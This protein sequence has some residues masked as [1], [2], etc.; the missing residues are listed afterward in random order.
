MATAETW[1]R[2]RPR[3]SIMQIQGADGTL[4]SW[5]PAHAL[6][7]PQWDKKWKRKAE[8]LGSG[9]MCPHNPNVYYAWTT[10]ACMIHDS[11]LYINIHTVHS[12]S[13]EHSSIQSHTSL[14]IVCNM[15]SKCYYTIVWTH[16]RTQTVTKHMQYT[17]CH[18]PA[19]A[20]NRMLINHK[21]KL[22]TCGG[23]VHTSAH[24][25]GIKRKVSKK[26]IIPFKTPQIMKGNKNVVYVV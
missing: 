25:K 22:T 20:S 1:L 10:S 6:P 2:S 19:W 18:R 5:P 24:Y 15:Y 26:C 3:G 8:H 23:L 7:A 16:I 21:L 17:K 14:V 4:R 9:T 12:F 11:L 13:T